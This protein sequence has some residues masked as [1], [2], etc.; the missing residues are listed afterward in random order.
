MKKTIIIFAPITIDK[1]N[2]LD[3][4]LKL[5]SDE[6]ELTLQN[7]YEIIK[8]KYN[9]NELRK[10]KNYS[11]VTMPASGYYLTSKLKEKGY[12]AIL[13]N[14]LSEYTI[15]KIIK[16]NPFAICISTTMIFKRET[17]KNTVNLLKEKF[18]ET[19]IIAG[20][21]FI[22]NSFL[23]N[24]HY[25]SILKYNNLNYKID[26]NYSLFPLNYKDIKLDFLIIS[27]HGLNILLNL[28][29]ELD[30]SKRDFSSFYNIA[31]P[32]EKGDF[33]INKFI[34][35]NINYN[36]DFTN[37]ELLDE[38]PDRIPIRTSIGCPYKCGYCNFCYLYPKLFLRSKKSIKKELN[39]INNVSRKKNIMPL[40]HV[41][42]DNVFFNKKRIDEITDTFIECKVTA[43]AGFMRASS[44]TE[45]NIKNIKNSGLFYSYIG[46]ESGDKGQLNR[47]N[48][49]QD[50]HDIKKG[51]ELLDKFGITVL[52]TF[53]IGYPGENNKTIE[54]TIQ[55]INKL[56]IAQSSPSVQLY[57]LIVLPLSYLSLSEIRK[58]WELNGMFKKW[59]H[60]T[61]DYK[62]SIKYSYYIFKNINKSYHYNDESVYFNRRFNK[63]TL[64]EIFKF[65][66]I[67]TV[68]LM[69]KKSID[70]IKVTLNKIAK[71]MGFPDSIPDEKF[72]NEILIP[73]L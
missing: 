67:L 45:N 14:N 36:E 63:D 16:I 61:M 64:K 57:P 20:G 2:D 41:V 5:K 39:L 18:P 3:L 19:Y 38:I 22:Y 23:W 52:M 4:I 12:N 69:E 65:R 13:I 30:K 31:I 33:I 42:D 66:N 29:I 60:K 10:I 28:L 27:Q 50:L 47:M 68:Q 62:K 9:L 6:R 56:E 15:E 55:F 26:Q 48:K 71:T 8:F 34:T 25:N 40:I 7:L 1:N 21:I 70:Q 54:N 58:K 59:K 43:W 35:E 72:I 49:K 11:T 24:N 44:I 53:L 32:N 37:W 73:E 46:V 17:L 51:I